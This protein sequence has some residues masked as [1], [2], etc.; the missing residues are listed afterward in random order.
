MSIEVDYYENAEFWTDDVFLRERPRFQAVLDLVPSDARSLIDIGCGNGAFVHY[1]ADSGRAFD[2]LH[3]TD[4]SAAAL[5]RVRGEKTA[6][7]IDDLPF[8]D[9]TFDVATCLEVIEHLPLGIYEKG[10]ENICRVA[11]RYVLLGVP[12]EENIEADLVRCPGCTGRFNP[13]Y[14]LR[15]YSDDA[16][17]GLLLPYGFQPIDR[18][19]TGAMREY[20]LVSRWMDRRR[21]ATR[22]GNPFHSPIP[23][24]MCGFSL[25]P[26]G[27]V[28]T[29][30]S[31]SAGA[32]AS[33]GLKSLVK[34][35]LYS[36]TSYGSIAKLYRRIE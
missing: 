7:S 35:L 29:E 12:F 36:N 21:H 6:A 34:K 20:F 16:L 27:T 31:A 11:R 22:T 5:A 30:A 14:H 3:A 23:C 10:L 24:P 15:S 32:V 8:K 25:P 18:V 26:T 19:L 33:G 1:I 13:N 4:R 9:R 17:N 28:A 2:R